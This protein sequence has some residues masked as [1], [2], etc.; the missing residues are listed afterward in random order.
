MKITDANINQTNATTPTEKLHLYNTNLK[1]L[2]AWLNDA[3]LRF[4]LS[5]HMAVLYAWEMHWKVVCGAY[6]DAQLLFLVDK[7]SCTD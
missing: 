5:N 2:F 4:K 3:R 1:S 7:V 6:Q